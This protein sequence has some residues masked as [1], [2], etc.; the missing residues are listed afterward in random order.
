M[1]TQYNKYQLTGG[2]LCHHGACDVTREYF[3][4]TMEYCPVIAEHC[5]LIMEYYDITV[6]HCRLIIECRD[7]TVEYCNALC[8]QYEIL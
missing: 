8:S 2:V 6:E 5:G 1:T 4:I 7:I 3:V